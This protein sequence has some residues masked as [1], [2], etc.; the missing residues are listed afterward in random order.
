[1]RSLW[2]LAGLAGLVACGPA[3]PDVSDAPEVQDPADVH[4]TDAVDETP[5]PPCARRGPTA[6]S[7][8]G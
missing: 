2:I 1:M 5:A 3:A 7:E 8:T 6:P 4:V